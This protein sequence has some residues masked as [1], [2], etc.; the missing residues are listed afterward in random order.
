MFYERTPQR[1]YGPPPP[2]PAPRRPP[3][4]CVATPG[5]FI[6]KIPVWRASVRR[7]PPTIDPNLY[8]IVE[9]DFK[10]LQ[11]IAE[12]QRNLVA[13]RLL[14][15]WAYMNALGAGTRLRYLI[16]R[17][18]AEHYMDEAAPDLTTIFEL[19][20]LGSLKPELDRAAAVNGP[21]V[22]LL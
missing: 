21:I 7:P 8:V 19:G 22:H 16:Q 2:Y 9:E 1:P 14:R 12:E 6:K 18:G 20:L 10:D 5:E 17:A 4:T 15:N 3:P 11:L 13:A